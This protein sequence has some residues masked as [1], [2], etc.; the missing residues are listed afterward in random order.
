MSD[1]M[2]NKEQALTALM[3]LQERL[4]KQKDAEELAATKLTLQQF[5]LLVRKIDNIAIRTGHTSYEVFRS[6]L[7]QTKPPGTDAP[8]AWWNDYIH[9]MWIIADSDDDLD[10]GEEDCWN[11]V[12]A[13]MAVFICEKSAP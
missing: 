9:F 6:M 3:L 13:N 12:I 4:A 8:T 2:T 1:T 7:Y 11:R 5:K 10:E